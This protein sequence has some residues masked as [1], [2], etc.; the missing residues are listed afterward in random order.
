MDKTKTV[1][2][3][4]AV[5]LTLLLIA[6]IY[7]VNRQR[8][9]EAASRTVNTETSAPQS[10]TEDTQPT[11]EASAT[12]DNSG[13]S[14]PE[15]MMYTL[16]EVAQHSTKDDCWMA[17][18]N[19]VYNVTDF[20]SRHPGGDAILQGCGKDATELFETKPM[21]SRTPHSERAR[22]NL[23]NFYIGELKQ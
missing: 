20:I 13:S 10:E 5:V 4:T 18:H 3:A 22:E 11:S 23:E 12:E 7:F 8:T 6:V 2:I 19:K 16:E 1:I 17:I 14:S 21:G 9:Q 15:T